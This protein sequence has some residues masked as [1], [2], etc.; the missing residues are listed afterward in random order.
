MKP[1]H[2]SLKLGGGDFGNKRALDPGDHRRI[3][4]VEHERSYEHAFCRRESKAEIDKRKSEIT[5]YKDFFSSYFVG[6]FSERN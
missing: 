6:N 2:R 5:R 4:A 1:E 3:Y